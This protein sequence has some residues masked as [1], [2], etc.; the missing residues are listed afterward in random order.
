MGRRVLR[1]AGR[2]AMDTPGG[3]FAYIV[4]IIQYLDQRHHLRFFIGSRDFDILYRWWEKR[5]PQALVRESLDRVVERRRRLR[6]PI[7]RFSVFSHEVR[8]SHRSFMILDIGRRGPEAPG[9]R[10]VIERFLDRFP[11]ELLPLRSEFEAFFRRRLNG[12]A[13]DARLLEEALLSLFE[14]DA[15]L[16]AKTAW[17]LDN[18]APRLRRPQIERTYRLNYLMNKFGF[19][20]LE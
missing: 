19:P 2:T 17:F 20:P 9:E 3:D 16:N 10:A 11:A 1:P 13:A 12:E 14:A 6:L 4:R 8:R 18:L 7:D 15:E 5:I